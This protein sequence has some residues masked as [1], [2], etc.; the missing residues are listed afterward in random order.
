MSLGANINIS[1]LLLCKDLHIF[2]QLYIQSWILGSLSSSVKHCMLIDSAYWL[3]KNNCT[4]KL[5]A[6]TNKYC[7]ISASEFH[8]L[9]LDIAILT[10]VVTITTWYY[11]FCWNRRKKKDDSILEIPSIP[12]P[13]PELCCSPLASVLSAS[14]LPKATSRKK[15]VRFINYYLTNG[16]MKAWRKAQLPIKLFF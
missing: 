15:Q 3:K 2:K 7:G 4:K 11:V 9:W 12:N 8:A 10:A 1:V 13:F 16:F 6:A 5:I 14:L